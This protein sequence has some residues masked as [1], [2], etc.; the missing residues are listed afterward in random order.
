MPTK[1]TLIC[2]SCEKSFER[3]SWRVRRNNA[4]NVY[5][6]RECLD[7]RNPPLAVLCTWCG[8]EFKKDARFVSDESNNFCSRSCS[9]TYNNREYPK[10]HRSARIGSDGK[11]YPKG[12]CESCGTKCSLSANRCQSC[13]S[14]LK[15]D[16]FNERTIRDVLVHGNGYSALYSQIRRRARGELECVLGR[17]KVCI[18]CGND[19]FAPVM[20]ASHINPIS[21]FSKDTKISEVNSSKNLAWMCPS[22]HRMFDKGLIDVKMVS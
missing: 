1:T 13:Y 3:D 19:E 15:R 10:R 22:H 12:I 14:L 7:N 11:K 4:K 17:P 16:E 21:E 20:Q 9:A 2:S 18:F 8:V 6:S 5:C